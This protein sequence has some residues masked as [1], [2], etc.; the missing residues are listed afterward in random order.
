MS[1]RRG[2]LNKMITLKKATSIFSGL[3]PEKNQEIMDHEILQLAIRKAEYLNFKYFLRLSSRELP[4]YLKKVSK[5]H[6]KGS[7][8]TR[9]GKPNL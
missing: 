2:A 4:K 8:T 7:M 6:H 3:I 9:L 1:S 5:D